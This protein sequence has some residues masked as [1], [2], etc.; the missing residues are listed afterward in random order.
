MHGVHNISIIIFQSAT[1]GSPG[2]RLG[3]RGLPSPPRTLPPPA[4]SPPAEAPSPTGSDRSPR[5]CDDTEI[6]VFDIIRQT[7]TD[8]VRFDEP[9]GGVVPLA[10]GHVGLGLRVLPQQR[11]LL[12][13]EGDAHEGVEVADA[14][15]RVRH[16]ILVPDHVVAKT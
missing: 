4:G 5:S 11:L 3:T 15:E 10:V 8:Y 6:S 13:P 14:R 16:Q 1:A 7:L 12:L 9:V 2:R